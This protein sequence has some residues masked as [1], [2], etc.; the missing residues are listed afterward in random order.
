MNICEH[1]LFGLAI[2]FV[3]VLLGIISVIREERNAPK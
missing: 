2:L 1:H 3:V